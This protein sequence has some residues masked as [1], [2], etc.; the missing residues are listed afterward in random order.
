MKYYRY[1]EYVKKDI[2]K[3]ICSTHVYIMNE[4]LIPIFKI[5][6][7]CIDCL[8]YTVYAHAGRY[9][10]INN[11]YNY[12]FPMLCEQCSYKLQ[13]CKWCRPSLHRCIISYTKKDNLMR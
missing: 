8:K 6:R 1:N 3:H 13:L 4:N 10:I 2:N 7:R 5:R 11:N 12:L 9:Q